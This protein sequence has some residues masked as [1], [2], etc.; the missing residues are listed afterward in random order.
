MSFLRFAEYT[1]NLLNFGLDKGVHFRANVLMKTIGRS[2]I[3]MFRSAVRKLELNAYNDFNIAEYLRKQ[4]ASIG[5]NSRIQIRSLGTEPYLVHIG[6]HCTIGTN[7]SLLTHDG[8]VW[9]F[10][11][12]F[13]TMQKFG[14]IR[15]LDNCFIG[16]NAI[17]LSNV[18]IGPNSVVGAG[19]VVT[20]SIPPNAVAAGNPA[21]VICTIDEYR[22]KSLS[23]W[24]DQKPSDYLTEME[25]GAGY[26]PEMILRMKT[27]DWHILKEHLIDKFMGRD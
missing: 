22:K 16:Q 14:P 7:V 26:S 17:I 27:R 25:D 10:T 9:V 18:T 5:E 2:I 23:I 1:L 24:D 12:E 15:I 4:G 6:N 11:G 20:K 21:R 8:A 13:P 3:N 19:S